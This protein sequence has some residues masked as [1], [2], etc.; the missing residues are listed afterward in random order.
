MR[1]C[2]PFNT[3][4]RRNLWN[5]VAMWK[6]TSFCS[7]MTGRRQCWPLTRSTSSTQSSSFITNPFW[8]QTLKE[9]RK[10]FVSKKKFGTFGI[11]RVLL[12][13]FSRQMSSANE[14]FALSANPL[15]GLSSDNHKPAHYKL[16]GT[17]N[18]RSLLSQRENLS[19]MYP[20]QA[21]SSG[22]FI[23]LGFIRL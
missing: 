5:H 1:A 16:S 8:W 10:Y 20:C 23:V 2:P 7:R 13:R 11:Q 9:A 17:F 3:E 4:P 15:D 6:R 19:F 22:F 14:N 18:I 12:S 21:V